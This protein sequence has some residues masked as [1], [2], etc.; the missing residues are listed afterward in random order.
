MGRADS[1]SDLGPLI[2]IH[3]SL[4]EELVAALAAPAGPTGPAAERAAALL[5]RV[6]ADLEGLLAE[7]QRRGLDV[8][9]LAAAYDRHVGRPDAA[10]PR[11][12]LRRG[13]PGGPTGA[14]AAV[15]RDGAAAG[16][17]AAAFILGEFLLSTATGPGDVEAGLRALEAAAEKGQPGACVEWAL[18]LDSRSRGAGD[19]ERV[20]SLL[21]TAADADDARAL[22]LLAQSLRTPAGDGP[23]FAAA[24]PLLERSAAAGDPESQLLIGMLR[25]RGFPGGAID[26]AA[27]VRW[28]TPA[29]AAHRADAGEWLHRYGNLDAEGY[30]DRTWLEAWTPTDLPAPERSGFLAKALAA[31]LLVLLIAGAARGDSTGAFLLMAFLAVLL[32]ECGHYFAARWTG[33]PVLV[34]SVGVGP[35]LRSLL[36]RRDGLPTRIEFRLLPLLGYVR[37]Y[38]APR[39]VWD[40][41]RERSR[42]AAEKRPPPEVPRFDRTEEPE[43]VPDLLPPARRVPY[44]VAGLA[45]NLLAAVALLWMHERV[46]DE[47][48]LVTVPVAGR[49]PGGSV[50]EAAGLREG[51]R[52]VALDGEPVRGFFDVQRRLAPVDRSGAALP[53]PDPPGVAVPLEVIRGGE[54]VALSWPTPT[55]PFPA[56]P[57]EAYGLYPA[58][59]WR[60]GRVRREVGEALRPGDLLVRF[61]SGG[62]RVES[63]DG[64]AHRLLREA[65]AAPS[66]AVRVTVERDGVGVEVDL[67][68]WRDP[69]RGLRPEPPFELERLREPGPPASLAAVAGEVLSFG[70]AFL[71][72]MPRAVV[73]GLLRGSSPE[74][75]GWLLAA[76]RRDPWVL[77]RTF[78]LI[79]AGLLFLNLLPIPPLDGFHLACCGWEALRGRPLSGPL[80]ARILKVG[81]ILLL[82]WLALNALL[83]LRDAA[84]AVL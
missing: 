29:A 15:W 17:G 12:A 49:V 63:G 23:D 61:E 59:S 50:A 74:E 40:H 3:A 60:V 22:R 14:A 35:A 77:L 47:A 38:A 27:A 30:L 7:G 53:L 20:R 66:A 42:R 64:D 37:P 56:E 55:A 84:T 51:D 8:P 75:R 9:T 65:F 62:R 41:W 44:L 70:A 82:A 16:S 79:H 4:R 1:A 13:I 71:V 80:R 25:A 21:R 67:G 31:G 48:R 36:V 68:A 73:G 57:R 83:I 24:V 6:Y 81:W 2:S 78:A 43:P 5:A 72:D 45:V 19:G 10:E 54:R 76:A 28:L 33:I 46:S 58:E 34:F 39:G 69:A 11:E 18:V 52:F 32:H 26:H